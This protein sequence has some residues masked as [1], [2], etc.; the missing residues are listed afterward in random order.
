MEIQPS[1]FGSQATLHW[2]EHQ[3][4]TLPWACAGFAAT[5]QSG[6]GYIRVAVN[7]KHHPDPPAQQFVRLSSPQLYLQSG[8][9]HPNHA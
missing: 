6:G 3:L 5:P 4:R 2:R 9:Q 1:D 7:I 8:P